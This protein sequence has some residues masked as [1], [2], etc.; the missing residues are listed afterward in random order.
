VVI[1]DNCSN[2]SIDQLKGIKALA[3][4]AV[5]FFSVDLTDSQTLESF[6]EEFH[7]GKRQ[8]TNVLHFAGLKSVSDS[9][10]QPGLYFEHNVCATI[11]LLN[12]I[13]QQRQIKALVFASSAAVYGAAESPISED[14]GLVPTTPY[15]A[16]KLKVEHILNQYL[17]TH[18]LDIGMLRYFNPVGV[19]P[20]GLLGE[21]SKNLMPMV[22]KSLTANKPVK[23]YDGIRDYVSI[24]DV[25]KACILVIDFLEQ[26]HKS[27]NNIFEVWN[28][29]SGKGLSV[30]QIIE[31]FSQVNDIDVPFVE[32]GKREGDVDVLVSDVSKA[33][34]QLGWYP[35]ITLE[36]SFKDLWRWYLQSGN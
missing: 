20:S 24:L 17:E 8:I 12:A 7:D 9:L 5:E 28:L 27:S 23:V 1:I 14:T 25:A 35:K 2:S 30:K 34:E 13:E 22:L 19:H 29:G 21:Q 10:S 3:F 32:C 16:T 18:F 15:G 26:N 36:E 6:F 31:L 11:N 33:Y 4:A